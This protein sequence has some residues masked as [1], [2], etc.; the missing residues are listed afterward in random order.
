V[1]GEG[2]NVARWIKTIGKRPVVIKG[3]MVP[4]VA[5]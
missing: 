4:G 3:M 1:T 5:S 2:K